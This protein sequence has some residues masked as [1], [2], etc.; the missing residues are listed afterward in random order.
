MGKH[1]D[2]LI[3]EANK[4]TF[5]GWLERLGRGEGTDLLYFFNMFF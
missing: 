4:I 1:K 3:K 5:P 2:G